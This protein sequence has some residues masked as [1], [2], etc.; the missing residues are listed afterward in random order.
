MTDSH[1]IRVY[2][3]SPYRKA[4]LL[5]TLTVFVLPLIIGGIL[6]HNQGLLLT[7]AI[8][9]LIMAPIFLLTAWRYPR[10]VL[11]PFG[12][13]RHDIG[14]VLT[15]TWHNVAE[16]RSDKGSQGL[17]LRQPMEDKGAYRFARFASSRF[18][19]GGASLYPPEVRHLIRTRRFIPMEAFAHWLRQGDLFREIQSR[20][21]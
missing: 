18:S 6:S 7:G 11:T 9:F 4:F 15:S 20:L 5:A 13:E 2:R 8:V 14:Y 21:P 3:L 12:V 1:R 16:M 10:L 19:M 17:I